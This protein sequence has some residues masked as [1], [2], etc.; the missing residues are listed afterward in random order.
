[1]HFVRTIL[2][3]LLTMAGT[4]M[5][6][7]AQDVLPELSSALSLFSA[8]ATTADGVRLNW[9]LDRQSP[10]IVKFR[11][12]RG[13]EEIGSFAVLAE[14]DA[15][16]GA[17]SMEYSY[18]DISARPSVSYFYKLAAVGQNSE[19]VFP[20]VITASLPL[21]GS[22]RDTVLPPATILRGD[23]IALYVRRTGHVKLSSVGSDARVLVDQEMRP[24]IYELQAPAGAHGPLTLHLEHSEGMTKEL[25]WPIE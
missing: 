13:Y 4:A 10:T 20:V 1:M 21:S 3:V 2:A 12:Y 7:S 17:D 16:S 24:G 5:A 23:A 22:A 19:S 14:I 6:G 15:R 11:V 8:Q 9:S 18:K 25:H